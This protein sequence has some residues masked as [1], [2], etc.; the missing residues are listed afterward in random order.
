MMRLTAPG[1]QRFA[2]A[3]SLGITY[4]GG[5]ANVSAALAHM[6]VSAA[7]VTVFPDNELG[8]AAGAFFQKT[9]R[10]RSQW[11]SH[12]SAAVELWAGGDRPEK[13]AG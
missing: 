11:S 8:R 6:G 5:E 13:S 10:S 12:G 2:Q 4:G 9:G 1:R 3:S 7:H